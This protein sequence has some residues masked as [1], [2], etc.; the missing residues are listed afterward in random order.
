MSSNNELELDFAIYFQAQARLKSKEVAVGACQRNH[1]CYLSR[2]R[3]E[4]LWLDNKSQFGGA[5]CRSMDKPHCGGISLEE[6]T[7]VASCGAGR[8][9]GS[10]S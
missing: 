7:P 4:M 2:G 6:A 8:R 1:R 3:K 10:S 9:P 5:H